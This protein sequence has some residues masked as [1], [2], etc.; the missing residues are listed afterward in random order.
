MTSRGFALISAAVFLSQGFKVYFLENFVAT[1]F[2]PFGINHFHA[3]AGIMVTASH[4]P[5]ADNGFKVY[6]GNGAQIIPPHDSNIAAAI[7]ENLQPWEKY[8][9]SLVTTNPLTVNATEEVASSYMQAILGLSTRKEKNALSKIKVAYTAMHGVGGQWIAKAFEA[10][11]HPS[12]EKVPSQLHPDPNFTTVSF[13][14][15]EEKGALNKAMEHANETGCTLILAND[16]DADRLA[17]AEKNTFTN[18]WRVFSGNEIGVLL[19]YWQIMQWKKKTTDTAAVLASIVSSRMLKTI[20]KK[21]GLQYYDTLT[22][23]KWLGNRAMELRAQGTPVLFSYEEALGYCVGDVLCDKDGISGASVFLE[24]ASA[25]SEGWTEDGSDGP[26]RSVADLLQGLNEKY[27]EFISYN[28]YVISHDVNK[29]NE[30]F[31]HL[32]RGGPDGGYWTHSVGQKIVAI[33]DVTKGYDSST[34]DHSSSLP[35]TPDSHMIMYEFENGVSVTLRT[36]GTEPKIKYYTEIAGKPGQ[37]REELKNLLHTFVDALVTEML[38]P[39][40]HG[41]IRV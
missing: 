19:G 10:F 16:P 36:S 28:S 14:N 17:V 3:A 1:P 40:K 25:L 20:A 39:E 34:S 13:P 22:G 11:D 21:E 41:L 26:Y 5:K 6:W 15:P 12:Y 27:G 31:A 37:S 29:T 38:E 9:T 24:M 30:I 7:L 33:T 4:N 18:T 23:F 32:R 2:V 35:M 8:D